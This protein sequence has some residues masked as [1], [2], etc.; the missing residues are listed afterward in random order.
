[1]RNRTTKIRPDLRATLKEGSEVVIVRAAAPGSESRILLKPDEWQE[2]ADWVLESGLPLRV[3]LQL[4]KLLWPE[5]SRG[6]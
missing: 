3:Q 5:V 6:V 1:M 2:L 4:H